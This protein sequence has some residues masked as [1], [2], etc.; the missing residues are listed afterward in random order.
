MTN[1]FL[2]TRGTLALIQ[3]DVNEIA[4]ELR[5]K[6]MGYFER[7]MT[8]KTLKDVLGFDNTQACILIIVILLNR[9]IKATCYK[10]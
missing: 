5:E 4:Q 6:E 8:S 2:L 3:L 9:G 1:N 7:A 10:G